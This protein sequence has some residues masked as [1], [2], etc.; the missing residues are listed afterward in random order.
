VAACRSEISDPLP[1][2]ARVAELPVLVMVA[3]GECASCPF[4]LASGG[5]CCCDASLGAGAGCVWAGGSFLVGGGD[6]SLV[7]G[8][9]L[10]SDFAGVGFASGFGRSLTESS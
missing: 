9:S 10:L 7:D 5:L 1:D 4:G 3:W 8:A 2:E 6:G